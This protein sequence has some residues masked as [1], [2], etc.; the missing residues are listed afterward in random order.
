MSATHLYFGRFVVVR[1]GRTLPPFVQADDY[2]RSPI[3]A[4]NGTGV[5]F[6]RV[7][8]REAGDVSRV[9][10]DNGVELNTDTGIGVKIGPNVTLADTL[11]FTSGVGS[12][13]SNSALTL[14]GLAEAVAVA[15]VNVCIICCRKESIPARSSGAV[16]MFVVSLV[17]LATDA[18]TVVGA[19]AVAASDVED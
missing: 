13:A 3:P 4:S 5:S 14:Q 15:G 17:V 12:A 6:P 2:A 16:M 9:F 11:F 7:A 10:A 19:A 1:R 18:G 8:V